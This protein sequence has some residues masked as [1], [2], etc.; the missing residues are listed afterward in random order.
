M[1]KAK[2][3]RRMAEAIQ[4]HGAKAATQN[5]SSKDVIG[6][7]LKDVDLSVVASKAQISQSNIER[8]LPA[9]AGQVY[10]LN[11]WRAT[12]G[13]L[14]YPTFKFHVR[15]RRS[16]EELNEAWISL[17]KEQA[18]LRTIFVQSDNASVPVLQV[19]L[20]AGASNQEQYYASLH[21]TPASDGYD[22]DLKIHHALYDA[23]SLPLLLQDLQRLL[24]GQ[25]A[26]SPSVAVDDFLALSLTKEA[27]TSRKS[28]WTKYLHDIH[29]IA[30]RQPRLQGAQNKVEI[31]QPQLTASCGKLEALARQHQISIQAILFAVYAKLHAQHLT[32]HSDPNEPTDLVLG[33]YLSNRGHLSDLD[34]LTCPTLNL[35][36]LCIRNILKSNIIECAQQIQSDLAQIGTV[37]NSST[38]LWEIAQWTGVKVDLFLNFLKLPETPSD[39]KDEDR[40]F[41]GSGSSISEIEGER[42]MPRSRVEKVETSS[43]DDGFADQRLFDGGVAYQ[44]CASSSSS[45]RRIHREKL[46]TDICVQHA[47]DVEMTV[48]DQGEL[49]FGLFAPQDMLTLEDGQ[50]LVRSVKEEL[51]KLALA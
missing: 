51:E 23:V 3:P 17:V 40:N 10:M 12:A 2:T 22:I 30:A 49:D 8:I 18:I 29:P 35:V 5:I 37:E 45:S 13:Q 20:K 1:L 14:F 24:D 15:T 41:N 4:A 32:P 26:S 46:F 34:Q 33:I 19:V 48:T 28:F 50:R 21:A 11:L 16:L 38:A 9:T 44:V 39:D 43:S 36:P 7:A 42:R 47:I 27:Q 6:V 31:F 25:P